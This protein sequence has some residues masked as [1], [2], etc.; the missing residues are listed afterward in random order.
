M[1]IRIA[2]LIL[3][4]CGMPSAAARAQDTNYWFPVGEQ[5]S[6]KLYW[7]IIPVGKALFTSEWTEMEGKKYILLRATADTTSLMA[8]IYPVHDIIESTVD[9][10]NFLPVRYVQKLREGRH[11]RDDSITFNHTN[12]IALWENT[13]KV[14]PGRPS[15]AQ[16]AI[17]PDTRDVLTLA[18]YMRK[19]GMTAG[20]KENFRV[21]V[22]NKLYDLELN[23][24]KILPMDAAGREDVE[25]I[26]VEPKAKFGAIFVRKGDVRLWFS[27][28]P[29]RV[30]VK[31]SAKLPV[32]S[33]KAILM[34]VEGP[35]DDDWVTSPVESE[36][37]K[38][39]DDE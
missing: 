17:Q 37:G 5:L 1:N 18:Y 31:M 20:Q 24:L 13:G 6:Y 23:G 4:L 26:E 35:G 12:G 36:N 15:S 27:Q 34:G 29:R 9:P 21:V 16:I 3:I 25:C 7:G 19:K 8:K 38:D 14:K 2:Y 32:A 33:V 11:K 39:E 28:D 22:D 30:C 10:T